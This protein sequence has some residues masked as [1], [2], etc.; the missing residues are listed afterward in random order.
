MATPV[1]LMGELIVQEANS[2]SQ[3]HPVSQGYD[4]NTF[5]LL[6]DSSLI[7]FFD[8][9]PLSITVCAY[10]CVCWKYTCSDMLITLWSWAGWMG[11]G[12]R[13]AFGNVCTSCAG[14]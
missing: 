12:E 7:L 9:T 11:W 8:I 10:V 3:R 6:W 4:Q 2:V 5:L 13:V 1:P 14:L